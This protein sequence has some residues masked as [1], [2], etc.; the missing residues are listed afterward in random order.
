MSRSLAGVWMLFRLASSGWAPRGRP[1]TS[2]F[3][4]AVQL[5]NHRL[6]NARHGQ[7]DRLRAGDMGRYLNGQRILFVGEGDFGFSA[8]ISKILAS[9][10][11]QDL[12][13]T[14]WDS[15]AKLESSFPNASA[16][17]RT[18]LERGG[19][20]LYG[21][22]ATKLDEHFAPNAFDSVV[23]MF[24]H[25]PGK[26]NIKRNRALLQS[27]FT[28]CGKVLAKEGTVVLAL[29]EGQ[30]GLSNLTSNQDWLHSW[31]LTA[32]AAEGGLLVSSSADLD[33]SE[34][35]QLGYSPLGH[36]GSGGTF[37]TRQ[38][39]IFRLVAPDDDAESNVAVQAPCFVHELHLLDSKMHCASALERA[40]EK[41][42]NALLAEKGL[43][44]SSLWSTL[45]VDF[46][47]CPRTQL[48]SHT[49]QLSYCSETHALGRAG[50]DAIRELVESELPAR[51]GLS[52]RS[53]KAGGKV[54]KEH[55]WPVA[56]ELRR[57]SLG[58]AQGQGQEAA[59]QP[60][61]DAAER[62]NEALRA[63]ED[64]GA[65]EQQTVT[66]N[67]GAESEEIK[68]IARGLWRRRVGVLINEVR[69]FSHDL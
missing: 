40:A 22:D 20:V 30:S 16:N 59:V 23:W 47:V 18:I 42:V 69:I 33:L 63:L 67:G 15:K 17:T 5:S 9:A 58:G 3:G 68:S 35:Q 38:A 28:S 60:C 7:I 44:T 27:F 46:Y 52:L 26:Q 57:L 19:T 2:L 48:L 54:S 53:E 24:P 66:E 51:L 64:H 41:A 10:D 12:K 13:A 1:L 34:F 21:I 29:A 14:T 25:V 50:A 37:P 45:L 11:G 4:S 36:R 65:Q 43:P 8:C 6:A 55:C 56:Q 61:S 31:K 32:A 62:L 49:L 39:E